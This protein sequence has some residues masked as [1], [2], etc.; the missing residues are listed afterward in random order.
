MESREGLGGES[1]KKEEINRAR[2]K[3]RTGR[4]SYARS[5]V[6][7]D[8]TQKRGAAHEIGA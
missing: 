8:V 7:G 5:A 4:D 1:L 2:S 3:K 6:E